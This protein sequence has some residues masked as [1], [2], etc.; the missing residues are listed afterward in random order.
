MRTQR[1]FQLMA[2]IRHQRNRIAR[3]TLED[4]TILEQH[5]DK[6]MALWNSF[7]ERLGVTEYKDMLFDLPSLIQAAELPTMDQLFYKRRNRGC[8]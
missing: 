1:F 8:T 6:E 2:T 5:H 4:G 3:L 7:K